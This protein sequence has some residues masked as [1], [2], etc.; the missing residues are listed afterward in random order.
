MKQ[1]KAQIVKSTTLALLFSFLAFN[2]LAEDERVFKNGN[3]WEVS[4]IEVVDGQWLNYAT[5]LKGMWRK[6]M[7]FS[8][9]NG[10]ISDYKIIINQHPR[11][12]EP[13]MYL[14]SIFSEMATKKQED[15][16][17]EAYIKWSKST[18]AKMEQESGER[19]V[20]RH[21]SGNSL[22]REVTFR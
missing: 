13:D 10:W 22:L 4:S 17:Y 7:E 5:H 1:M 14:I 8:K 6:S 12:G 16:R 3:Y 21:L 15:E 2:A 11:K 19:M 18:I 20:M 9:S